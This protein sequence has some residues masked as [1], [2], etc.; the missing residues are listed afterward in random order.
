MIGVE[1]NVLTQ[2]RVDGNNDV[3]QER[4]HFYGVER[5]NMTELGKAKKGKLYE[6]FEYHTRVL[7]NFYKLAEYAKLKD[8]PVYNYCPDSLIDVFEKVGSRSNK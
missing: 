8:I 5:I 6:F 1:M 2:I 7:Y 3:I 4:K